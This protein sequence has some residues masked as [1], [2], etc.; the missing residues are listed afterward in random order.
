[1]IKVILWDIDGTILDFLASENYAVK[2]CFSVFRLGECTDEM[3]ERYSRINKKYWT[4]LEAGKITKPDVLRMRYEDFFAGEG[5]DF[6][7]IDE[8][9]KEYQVR[10]GDKI[11]FNDNAPELLK[12]LKNKF[13]QYAVTNGTSAAQ[14]R[15][16]RVSGL[17]KLLDGVFISDKIGYE[18]PTVQF[19]NAVFKK[20]GDYKKDEIMII[21]DSLTSDIQGGNNTGIK[22]CLYNPQRLENN[23][24][25]RIDLEITDLNE[26]EDK[27]KNM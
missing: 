10:L 8:L 4:M 11:F 9:N 21:G 18:K 24:K 15:K 7:Q 20:I 17:D 6:T 2:K 27:L 25:L 3:V 1:M 26:I 16:I 19:F 5:I 13:K 22:C 23:T 12:R 14:E